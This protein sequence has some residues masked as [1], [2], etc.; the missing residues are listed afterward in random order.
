MTD[1]TNSTITSADGTAIS[2]RSAGNGTGVIVVGGAFRTSLDYLPFAEV[3]AGSFQVHVVDRRGRGGS[4]P[5]GPHYCLRREIEDLLAIRAHTGARFV[6]GH[7]YGGLIALHT[8]T[9]ADTFER[10]AVYEPGVSV[11][12]SIP[13]A[14]TTRYREL[15][16]ANDRR[17]AFAHFVQQVGG[18][19]RIVRHLPLWYLKFVLRFAIKGDKLARMDPLLET[20][21]AEHDEVAHADNDPDFYRRIDARV[22]LLGG[23][24]SP[25]YMTEI[26]FEMLHQAIARCDVDILPGLDHLAPD[27]HHPEQV[28]Q[29]VQR[30]L[31]TN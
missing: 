21:A 2:I 5:Q 4:G 17:G 19:P 20:S 25:R 10:V 22:L 14:W 8:A 7:S 6:F 30:F 23:G 16:A 13:T 29:R 3:L 24:R 11:N 18:G 31:Q 9:H 26:P 1:W 15:L 28:A 27:D 12:G